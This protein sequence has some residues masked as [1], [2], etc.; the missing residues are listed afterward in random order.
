MKKPNLFVI[1]APK[2]G[3]TALCSYLEKH[4]D[5][6]FSTPKEPNYFCTDIV[7]DYCSASTEEEYISRCFPIEMSQYV[8]VGD[9]SVSSLYSK[10]AVQN[11][12]RFNPDAKFVVMLRNPIEL[13]YSLHGQLLLNGQEDVEDFIVAWRL[14]EKRSKGNCIPKRC[15]MPRM[16]Q[17][18][19]VGRLGA[20]LDRLYSQVSKKQVLVLLSEEL[21]S[22]PAGE[23]KKVL[24]FLNLQEHNP[25]GFPVV[26]ESQRNRSKHL[27]EMLRAIAILKKR[28]NI[29]TSFGI[30]TGLSQSNVKPYK[31]KPLPSQFNRELSEYFS[32]DV[33]KLSLIIERDCTHWI[34]HS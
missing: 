4:P 13:V 9:G 27:D 2:C 33:E 30:L 18:G 11:I 8:I 26:N 21:K 32:E 17:Y 19:E 25:D 5:I 23:Y 34:R 24:Q 10:T 22:N 28:L 20:Q 1:G 7:G 14:Q 29:R 16:L 15:M 6:I 3:T 31:R 12:L